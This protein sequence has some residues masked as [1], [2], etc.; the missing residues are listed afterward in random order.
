MK[1]ANLQL[2]L[3]SLLLAAVIGGCGIVN[4]EGSGDDSGG[5]NRASVVQADPYTT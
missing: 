3:L 5:D 4:S 2:L 1:K